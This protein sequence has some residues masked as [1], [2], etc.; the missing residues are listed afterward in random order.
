MESPLNTPNCLYLTSIDVTISRRWTYSS[1]FLLS[2]LAPC[3]SRYA[4]D[5]HLAIDA[6]ILMSFK[7]GYA[8]LETKQQ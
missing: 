1:Q 6:K 5:S 7:V 4:D 8:S 3:M 2:H